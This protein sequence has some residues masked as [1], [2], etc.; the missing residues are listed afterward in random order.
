MAGVL[1][2]GLLDD[3]AAGLW[4]IQQRG[5]ATVVQDPEEAAYRSMPESAIRGLNVQY[6]VRLAEM[7]PLLSRLTMGD[8]NGRNGS[9]AMREVVDDRVSQACPECGGVMKL[10]RLGK[11]IEYDCHVGHRFGLKTMIAEKSG[12]VERAIWSALAQS[13]ELVD[14]LEQAKPTVDPETT[15]ALSEEITERRKEQETLRQLIER[16]KT[17]PLHA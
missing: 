3:G 2:T 6:I 16:M 17:P 13:E 15:Q 12:K 14:L 5:G 1:L 11:L 10:H 8:Q 4:E 9:N 7:A